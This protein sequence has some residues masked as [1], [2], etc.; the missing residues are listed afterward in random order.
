MNVGRRLPHLRSGFF[1]YMTNIILEEQMKMSN[2]LLR[3]FGC[4]YTGRHPKISAVILCD[5]IK[6]SHFCIKLER[7]KSLIWRSEE[8]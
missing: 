7:I 6:T 4:R 2:N 3:F 8:V 1:L 5:R